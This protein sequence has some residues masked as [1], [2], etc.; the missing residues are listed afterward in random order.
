MITMGGKRH[1]APAVW[2]AL[3][4]VAHYV[5]PFCRSCAVLLERPHPC[6]RS[7]FSETVNDLDG[8]VVNALRSLAYYPQETAEAA[9]WYVSEACMHARHLALLAWVQ[10][11][12]V[13]RL[14]GS[15]EYY[16]PRIAGYYLYGLS[17]WIGAGWCD[18]RGPWVVDPVSGKMVKR[19]G[20]NGV[21][22]KRPHVSD[23]G[24]GVTHAGTRE[25][26]VHRPRPHVSDDG[27]GVNTHLLRE[28]GVHRP[29]PHLSHDGRAV[30]KSSLWE[31]GVMPLDTP[32]RDTSV[33][34]QV[35]VEADYDATDGFHPMT[36]PELRR[37]FDYL[38]ARLRH[39]RILN[40]DWSRAVTHGALNTL[41]VREKGGAVGVFL[42]P[43]Y[44]QHERD[45]GI[46][47][48]DGDGDLLDQVRAW[49]LKHGDTPHY[50]IVLAGFAGEGHEVL[51]QHGWRVVEWFHQQ[52][53]TGG[54]GNLGGTGNHQQHRE[55][56]WM[57]PHTI[58]TATE[59]RQLG[60]FVTI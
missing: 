36:M 53:L 32:Q 29:R 24:Q 39:V 2:A 46:Y 59:T 5:E 4:D 43:P 27:Q 56:L 9:S 54:M 22:R 60:L 45:S 25:P 33:P 13:D 58:N 17:S 23:N 8:L 47:A 18:G 10:N 19:S 51:E 3:G 11:G 7:Y 38:S 52:H 50:R 12:A 21:H 42:D 16:E 35:Q 1:A 48:H 57:S 6:N 30:H 31:P 44:S 49:C 28:P 20:G 34:W 55:R 40:G 15:V 37:W 14:C 41:S 26:G